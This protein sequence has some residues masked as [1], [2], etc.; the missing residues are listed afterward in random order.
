MI[1]VISLNPLKQNIMIKAISTFSLLAYCFIPLFISCTSDDESGENEIKISQ[2]FQNESHNNGL[3]CMTCHKPGGAGEGQFSVAGSVY[4][5]TKTNDYPNAKI[6]L[7]TGPNGTGDLVKT[8]EVDGL[9][10]FYTTEIIDL[11]VGLYPLVEGSSGNQQSMQSATTNGKCNS[12]HGVT[13]E[14][15]WID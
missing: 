3:D 1:V 4:D 11:S 7:F 12:C 2:N 14:K 9:G 6:Q 8:I 13:I 10:N 5:L 15:I